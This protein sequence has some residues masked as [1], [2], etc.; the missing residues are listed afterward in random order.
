MES[1]ER[2]DGRINKKD[3][4]LAA[5]SLMLSDSKIERHTGRDRPNESLGAILDKVACR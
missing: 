1:H 3:E 2:K 4:M 5:E